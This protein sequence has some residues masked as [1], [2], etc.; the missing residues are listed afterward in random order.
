MSF[1]FNFARSDSLRH[2]YTDVMID[3]E[4]MGTRPDA[5]VVSIGVQPFDFQTGH[6]GTNTLYVNVDL[7]SSIAL[8]ARADGSTVMWWLSQSETARRALT[9][10][11]GRH[12]TEALDTVARFL[13]ENT[14]DR[15][16]RIVWACGTDFDPVILREHYSRSSLPTPWAFW[17]LMDFRTVRKLFGNAVELVAR[18]GT[19]HNA[20][21][22]ARSQVELLLTIRKHLES[23]GAL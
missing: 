13:D 9:D 19:H 16:R 18:S 2:K 22:D 6:V 1:D 17:N 5:P 11:P 10:T 4:S 21:D 14:V 8:G 3:I 15:Q 12:V 7:D 20:L 23:K